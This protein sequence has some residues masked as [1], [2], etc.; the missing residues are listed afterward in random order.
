MEP[1]DVHSC[2]SR[3]KGYGTSYCKPVYVA[4]PTTI[5][6]PFGKPRLQYASQQVILNVRLS[7]SYRGRDRSRNISGSSNR[8]GRR[9]SSGRIGSRSRSGQRVSNMQGRSLGN[10]NLEHCTIE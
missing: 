8:V 6:P 2:R 3:D 1:G 10:S 4:P 5:E 7:W 9:S